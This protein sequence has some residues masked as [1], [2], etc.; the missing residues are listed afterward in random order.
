MTPWMS[1]PGRPR[2]GAKNSALA[3]ASAERAGEQHHQRR[4][5]D[6]P[7]VAHVGDVA[8]VEREPDERRR[9]GQADQAQRQ[10]VARDVVHLPGD[11]DPLDLRA[12]RHRQDAGDEPAEIPDTE[13]CVGIV[14]LRRGRLALAAT[15]SDIGALD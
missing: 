8:G 7:P 13:G 9:L 3:T 12:H 1:A 6:A 14:G 15:R 5:R 4:Q 2:P 11:D 10:R